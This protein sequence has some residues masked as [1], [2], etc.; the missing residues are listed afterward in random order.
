MLYSASSVVSSIHV[1]VLLLKLLI[2]CALLKEPPFLLIL[3]TG[4]WRLLHCPLFNAPITGRRGLSRRA[5]GMDALLAIVVLL[6]IPPARSE[7]DL[8]MRKVGVDLPS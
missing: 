3:L 8:V 1:Q 5:G 2:L 4:K 7:W 6:V